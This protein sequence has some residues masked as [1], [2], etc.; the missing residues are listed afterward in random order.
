VNLVAVEELVPYRGELEVDNDGHVRFTD[1][2]T[3][4]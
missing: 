2:M 3:M 4:G 1:A